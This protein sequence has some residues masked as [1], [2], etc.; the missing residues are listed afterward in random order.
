MIDTHAHIYANRFISDRDA[1]LARAFSSGV[2]HIFMPNI[3]TASLGPMLQLAKA[4]PA[5]CF[6]M[7][8]L[9]PCAVDA[10]F[11][12]NLQQLEPYLSNHKFVAIG[13]FGLDF[14]RSKEYAEQQ[15]NAFEIQIGWA[16]QHNL[17]VV[18]HSRSSMEET[19]ALLEKHK[20]D[21]LNGIVHCFSGT[22]DQ[23]KR[24]TALGFFLGLG[25]V[26][27]FKNTGMDAVVR[28]INPAHIVLETDC[29][30]LAPPPFRGKRN[31]PA[32][33]IHIAEKVAQYLAL[34][35]QTLINQTDQNAL[36]VYKMSE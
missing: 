31:E 9:H 26:V 6:P 18:I 14:Y 1:M 36:R 28:Q 34:D 25:G 35:T 30:Y 24:L 3:D 19:I 7:L 22:A 29:P 33:L 11:E 32:Y 13:E 16:K 8:G 4:Y 27:T 23:A 10:D 2:S 12:K 5:Q 20:D 15:K 21:K 17:P